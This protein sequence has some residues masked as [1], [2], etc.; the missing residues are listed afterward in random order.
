MTKVEITKRIE[1]LKTQAFFIN[2]TDHL[3]ND[4]WTLLREVEKEITELKEKLN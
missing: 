3:T 1:E 4:D 2:M